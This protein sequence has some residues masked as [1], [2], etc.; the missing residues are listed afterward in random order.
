MVSVPEKRQDFS[1][2]TVSVLWV[3]LL[4]AFAAALYC[5]RLGATPL[6]VNAE[7]RTFEITSHMIETGD[8]IVPVFRGE[9][10]FNKPPLYYWT[11]SVLANLVGSKNLT[12]TIHRLPS[13]VT[14]LLVLMLGMY[15]GRLL[16]AWQGTLLGLTLLAVSYLYVVQARRGSFEMLL[17]LMTNL[18]M[19]CFYLS[20][21]KRSMG[22]ALL[23]SLFWGLGFL[24]K[25][26]PVI[27]YVPLVLFAWFMLQGKLS[28]LWRKELIGVLVLGGL[29]AV[30]WYVY[31][32][33]FRPDSR[34][35]IL[36][37]ALLP[38]GIK[39][40]QQTT[41]EHR[42]PFYFYALNI[43]RDAFP[44][45]L[46][47]P[48]TIWHWIRKRFYEPDSPE[49]L[50]LLMV[51]IPFFVFSAIPMKQVH[52]LLPALLPLAIL[53]GKAIEEMGEM[54]TGWARLLITVPLLLTGAIAVAGG[55]VVAVGLHIVNDLS[56]LITFLIGLAIAACGVLALWWSYQR[57]LAR[58][59]AGASIGI[60]ILFGC[61]FTFVR[62]IEDGF[63]SGSLLVSP[64]Y[65][66]TLWEAKFTR[67]PL[68]RKLL[69]YDRGMRVVEKSKK[70]AM[71]QG[72]N[73]EDELR[74]SADGQ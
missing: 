40:T 8:Y 70:R 37:E 36:G 67:Y 23:G 50:L 5:T 41:A 24:T 39:A 66:A 53:T 64:Q 73:L 54:L 11:V 28:R 27:L 26:T 57:H 19:L 48:L 16:R 4:I 22:L 69:D 20:T 21:K 56:V 74:K 61:Y 49:R 18:S 44:L 2:G 17:T 55:I 60:G 15:W 34:S 29:I 35:D 3:A 51:V 10:R 31:I 33:I 13:A 62:P 68:L 46:F 30:S 47:L 59:I 12:L 52:Y 38:L 42:G 63:G 6:R 43:W 25:A 1:P 65:N 32:L 71:Q 58:A 45:S 9:T 7:I 14:A 72:T